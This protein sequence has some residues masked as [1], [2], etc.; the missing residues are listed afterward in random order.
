MWYIYPKKPPRS[1]KQL[2]IPPVLV[3]KPHMANMLSISERSLEQWMQSKIV[4]YIKI[5]GTVLFEP[6]EVI[7]SVRRFRIESACD[8]LS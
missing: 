6:D 8:E 5:G 2:P 3:R 7:D 4:P 1:M